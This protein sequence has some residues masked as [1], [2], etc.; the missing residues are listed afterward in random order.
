[1]KKV[2]HL[3]SLEW[4][5]TCRPE[6]IRK[7]CTTVVEQFSSVAICLL[8]SVIVSGQM[9]CVREWELKIRWSKSKEQKKR[10]VDLSESSA[11]DDFGR[12]ASLIA[13]MATFTIMFHY[14][15]AVSSFIYNRRWFVTFWPSHLIRVWGRINNC[16][17]TIGQYLL[18]R[19]F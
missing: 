6:W 7:L 11:S 1:M 9:R 10:C 2:V 4:F 14:I 5:L 13:D 15:I 12:F 8:L 3:R 19:S 17:D 16:L 18:A